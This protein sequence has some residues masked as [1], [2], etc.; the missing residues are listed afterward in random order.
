[1]AAPKSYYFG[2][3]LLQ[4]LKLNAVKRGKWVI[5]EKI[6]LTDLVKDAKSIGGFYPSCQF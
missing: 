2:P 4:T 3:N 6:H 1:M 5:D